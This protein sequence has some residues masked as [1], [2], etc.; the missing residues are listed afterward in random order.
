MFG[1]TITVNGR[2]S[3]KEGD[4]NYKNIVCSN[5]MIHKFERDKIFC[6]TNDYIILLDG[7]VLNKDSL[8]K[9]SKDP[10]WV[11]VLVKKY[12]Q[13]G[14]CFFCEL[15]GSFS[16]ALYDKKED[17]WIVYGD[18]LG[19]KFTYYALIG[20]FFCCSEVMGHMYHMLQENGIH[21][22]LNADSAMLLLT[23]GYMVDDKT[24]CKE[25]HK[26]NPGCYITYKN[27]VLK[28]YRYYL[29][30]NSPVDSIKED[31]A[32]EL[33]DSY[34]RKA[35]I[36]Q[37]EKDEEYG[38]KHLVALSG[39]LDARMT[40]FV[41]HDCG[42]TNQLNM[43]FSQCD[44]LDQTLPMHMAS[45][46][47][48]EWVFKALDNGLWLYD[49]DEITK[50]TGGNVLYYGAAHCNSLLK[51]LNF[52]TLGIHH[53]GQLGDVILG[54]FI[55]SL[56]NGKR[57]EIGDKAYSKT[58]LSRLK[59]IHLQQDLNKELGMLY[60][61]GLNGTNNGEQII[62][63][64]TETISPFCDLDFMEKALSLPLS[65]RQNHRLY[66]KWIL[67]KYPH[68]AAFKWET[69]GQKITAP[70]L[71]I[72]G[73]EVPLMNIPQRIG[74][75]IRAAL[76]MLP[77]QNS[78]NNMNPIAY[79]MSNNEDL[80]SY[81]YS[82]FKY[83]DAICNHELNKVIR[84]IQQKGSSIEINQAISLLAAVKQFFI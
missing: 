44:Y 15:R 81:L 65:L 67:E 11:D 78:K 76:G 56:D 35:I 69:T 6:E 25:I 70:V 19:S 22:S 71:R 28:E 5:Y 21:Y 68:A 62:Y 48:H 55:T 26:I 63:N 34:F 43:T 53:S 36:K 27:G 12:L 80:R 52:D 3:A 8:M 64:Y 73:K 18:Q 39:G 40:T 77:N 20:D 46:L 60:Y 84:E 1:Y 32:V 57:Y 45:T 41:A 50:T 7:V 59:D 79:Y 66:K 58:Y 4:I 2:V 30:D 33:I 17:K 37:F 13:N 29:L 72:R 51:Y 42:Y 49:V 38:Y 47:R 24:L 14:D 75:H 9:E 16:G 23:Y 83:N 31:E 54:S 10:V 61:R 82:Y 74:I